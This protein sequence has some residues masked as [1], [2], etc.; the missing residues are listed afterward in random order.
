MVI[1]IPTIGNGHDNHL[2]S[3]HFVFPCIFIRMAILFFSLSDYYYCYFFFL[4]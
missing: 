3:N 2:N 4:N 1:P